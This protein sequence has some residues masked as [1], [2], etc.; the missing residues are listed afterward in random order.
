MPKLIQ[1][2]ESEVSRGDGTEFRPYRN[3]TQYHTPEGVLLAESDPYE[4]PYCLVRGACFTQRGRSFYNAGRLAGDGYKVFDGVD[5]FVSPEAF[6]A[7]E[8]LREGGGQ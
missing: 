7:S 6:D 3:V 2:I 1:V 4:A 8:A 5:S